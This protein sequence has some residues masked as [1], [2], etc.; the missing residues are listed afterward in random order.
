MRCVV[1]RESFALDREIISQLAFP[2]TGYWTPQ[3]FAAENLPLRRRS[4][5]PTLLEGI[6]VQTV[7]DITE[8]VFIPPTLHV[9]LRAR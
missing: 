6:V 1:L 7:K 2:R 9:V 5:T 3:F 4:F 8:K